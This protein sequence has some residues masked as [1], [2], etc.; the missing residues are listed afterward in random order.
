MISCHFIIAKLYKMAR[1]PQKKTGKSMKKTFFHDSF[2]RIYYNRHTEKEST[3][4][5]TS[6]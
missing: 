4:Y 6:V 1:Q 2:Y 3:K 5:M